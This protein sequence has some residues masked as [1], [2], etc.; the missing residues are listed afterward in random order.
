MFTLIQVFA[1]VGFFHRAGECRYSK[2]YSD[3]TAADALRIAREAAA[4]NMCHAVGIMVGDH[5]KAR[6]LWI[7]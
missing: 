3:A 2:I 6:V 7:K 1:T 5:R 4:G